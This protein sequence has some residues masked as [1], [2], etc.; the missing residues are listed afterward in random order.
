YVMDCSIF[1]LFISEITP[2]RKN[3]GWTHLLPICPLLNVKLVHLFNLANTPETIGR[4][5]RT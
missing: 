3:E 5:Q 2:R 4:I 1:I